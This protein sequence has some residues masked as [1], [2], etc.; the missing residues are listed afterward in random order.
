MF[1]L[2]IHRIFYTSISHTSRALCFARFGFLFC[3]ELL[4]ASF[5][6]CKFVFV[7][8]VLINFLRQ[9]RCDRWCLTTI[10]SCLF[11]FHLIISQCVSSSKQ[12]YQFL[13]HTCKEHCKSLLPRGSFIALHLPL[14]FSWII[15]LPFFAWSAILD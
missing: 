7:L 13:E 9:M 6:F 5:G 11:W 15:L 8:L 3:L 4:T 14:T 2:D 10:P 1:L 12:G